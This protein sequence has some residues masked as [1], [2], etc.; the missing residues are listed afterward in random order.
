MYPLYVLSGISGSGKT[1]LG[2]RLVNDGSIKDAV[3]VDQDSYYLKAKPTTKLSNGTIVNN[4]DCI[5]A[6]DASFKQSI[7]SMLEKSPVVLAGF[8]LIADILPV[9]PK[10]HIHLVLAQNPQDLL[11]RCR[12]ARLQAKPSI[13]TT[14]DI[15]VVREIVIPFYHEVV[16]ESDITHLLDV[17]DEET[18][19]RK[20]LDELLSAIKEII[21]ESTM[22]RNIYHKMDIA[23]PYFDLIR[24]GIK[25]VEGRKISDTWKK[26]RRG[27][28]IL[29][30]T[31]NPKAP[32]YTVIVTKV[33]MYLPSIGDP[34][35]AY[36]KEE[37]LDRALP[38][39]KTI[40]EGR[41]V[42][43]QWS[44]EDEIRKMGMMGI[45]LRNTNE[46]GIHSE[47]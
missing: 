32:F 23:Q 20:S 25:P 31:K 43:L 9:I 6:L 21:V 22:E 7:A 24:S 1:T 17:F 42:Y 39:V 12:T 26:V 30:T 5:E 44:S 33:R 14:R 13:D 4:W 29:V 40:E 46:V 18:G 10:V 37:G 38:G 35:T 11:Q 27:D 15:Y 47:S 16:R 3:F 2:Q 34:L 8:A 19:K 41:K 28:M 45:Q 36:L